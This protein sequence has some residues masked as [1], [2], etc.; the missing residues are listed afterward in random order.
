MKINTTI[1]KYIWTAHNS[2]YKVCL[3]LDVSKS[4]DKMVYSVDPDQTAPLGAV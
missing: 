4:T 2:H 3:S 1:T